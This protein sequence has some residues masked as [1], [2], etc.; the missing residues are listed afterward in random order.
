MVLWKLK[1]INKPF[2]PWVFLPEMFLALSV[3]E[4]KSTLVECQKTTFHIVL[5]T[6]QDD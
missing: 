4:E 2:N 5:F 3:W 6:A 1:L